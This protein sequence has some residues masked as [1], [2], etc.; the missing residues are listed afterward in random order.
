MLLLLCVYMCVY[1][2]THP[3]SALC[4]SDY[5][6]QQMNSVLLLISSRLNFGTHIKFF[7]VTSDATCYY[8]SV[9]QQYT[10]CKKF[11]RHLVKTCN[12]IDIL[13]IL[14]LVYNDQICGYVSSLLSFRLYI[15]L[16][17]HFEPVNII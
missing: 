2:H 1:T 3:I 6:Y 17:L 7:C 10:F 15:L 11:L 13:F 14:Y 12:C 5:N 8:V 4:M 9:I 16:Q